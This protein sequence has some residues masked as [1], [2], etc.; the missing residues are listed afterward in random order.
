MAIIASEGFGWTN[1]TTDLTTLGQWSGNPSYILSNGVL[2]DN[3]LV[4]SYDGA[5][6]YATLNLPS[7]LTSFYWGSRVNANGQ[8]LSITYNSPYTGGGGYGEMIS[9]QFTTTGNI[10][11]YTDNGLGF[12]YSNSVAT[13]APV[14]GWF[15][16]EVYG[17]IATQGAITV[18]INGSQVFND[19]N[20]V[21]TSTYGGFQSVSAVVLSALNPSS[22]LANACWQHMYVC[23]TTGSGPWNTFLGDVRVQTLLPTA[24]VAVGFTP[25]GGTNW[26]N[27]STVPPNPN[28][29]YNYSNTVGT[30]DTFTM[31]PMSNTLGTIYG[32]NVKTIA[33]KT[34]AGTREMAAVVVSSGTQANGTNTAVATAFKQY[35]NVFETCPSTNAQW[36]QAEVNSVHAGYVI[37]V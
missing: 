16:L 19:S 12:R 31:Q 28:V 18:R 10:N 11:V 37:T 24:N 30:Q 33:N 5:A 23:D 26:Q 21:T 20:V 2:G 27:M 22:G 6:T 34:N 13:T 14:N 35:Q 29:D 15:Y 9:V 1:S 25:N 32:V 4:T 36:T 7:V 3:Y 17:L 8:G